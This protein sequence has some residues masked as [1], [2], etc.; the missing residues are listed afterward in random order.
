MINLC[1]LSFSAVFNRACIIL[2]VNFRKSKLMLI[3]L[4]KDALFLYGKVECKSRTCLVLGGNR[5]KRSECSY[6]LFS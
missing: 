5:R 3:Y 2:N 4:F 6:E 1:P